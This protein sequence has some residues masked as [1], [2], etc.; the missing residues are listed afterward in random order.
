M[1]AITNRGTELYTLT[2]TIPESK[3]NLEWKNIKDIVN[4]FKVSGDSTY[5][6]SGFY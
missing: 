4:S 6:S 2:A 1:S 5:I 3:Y